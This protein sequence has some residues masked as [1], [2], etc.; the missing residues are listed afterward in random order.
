MPH[1]LCCVAF[2]YYSNLRTDVDVARDD[3]WQALRDAV[4]S[5]RHIDVL[6]LNAGILIKDDL[7]EL[8]RQQN[9]LLEQA[10]LLTPLSA[11]MCGRCSAHS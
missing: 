1:T 7:A 2:K 9:S 11:S 10:R 4:G 5:C 8:S 3:G 6:I